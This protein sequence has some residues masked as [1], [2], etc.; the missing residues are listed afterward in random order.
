MMR[1]LQ[2]DVHR[3]PLSPFL[4]II[5]IESLNC[6]F[7]EAISN[8]TLKGLRVYEDGPLMTHLQFADDTLV[9]CGAELNEII[10]LK[11]LLKVLEVMTGLNINFHESILCGVG[12][13]Q[14]Q[15]EEFVGV[16]GCK[17][18]FPSH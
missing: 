15:L 13:D 3:D 5:A 17:S 2:R 1:N 4:F 7:L 11:S 8:G 12:L 10:S 14:S 9:F 6:L 16:L 18:Q